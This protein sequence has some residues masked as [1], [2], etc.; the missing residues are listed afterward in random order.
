M[1]QKEPNRDSLIKEAFVKWLGLFLVVISALAIFFVVSNTSVIL[2]TIKEYI[3]ILRPVIYGCVI[4]YIL[5]PLMKIYKDLLLHIFERKEKNVSE[6]LQGIITGLAIALA[7][8]TGILVIII[9]CWMVI[10]QLVE[11]LTSLV[12]K[13]PSQANYYYNMLNESIKNNELL[14]DQLQDIALNATEYTEKMIKTELLPWLQSDLLPSVNVVAVEFANGVMS[15]FNILYNFFIGIIVAIYILASK[16]TFSAQAKKLVYGLFPKKHASVIIH[17]VRVSNKMFSGFITGK[18][19]DST[20]VG[21]I[22]FMMM[23]IFDMPYAMLVSVIVGVTNVIPVF[24]PYIG[25]IPSAFLIL[26]IDPMQAFYFVILIAILQQLDG[27][28]IGPAILGESTGLS[29]FW[30]LFA[31][32]LFGGMWGIV[33]MIIGVPL[34][35]VIYRIVADAINWKLRGKSLSTLTDSYRNLKWIEVNEN[36]TAFYVKYTDNELNIEKEEKRKKRKGIK[37]KYFNIERAMR[38]VWSNKKKS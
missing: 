21:M 14:Q 35:A 27:N 16:T 23:K 30:V 38:S 22:C 15:V 32:L 18:I 1:E 25:L 28:I 2:A 3:G 9:L 20:I 24:G 31:I 7:L 10:P 19:V 36:N 26:L 34:F 37:E 11:S 5:N 8:L 17:Y 6:K 12:N 29:A 13:L 4:A 33:G